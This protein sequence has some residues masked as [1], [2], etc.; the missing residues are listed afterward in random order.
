MINN[1][2]MRGELDSALAALQLFAKDAGQRA[3]AVAALQKEPDP[4]KLPLIEKAFAAETDAAIKDQLGLTQLRHAY[5]GGEAIGEDTFV[6]YRALGVKLRQLYGQTE[7][8][9]YNAMQSPEEVRLH[10]VGRPLPG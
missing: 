7:T 8:S 4:A 3:A 6:F 1:N 2:R 10:T 5:T 9:A